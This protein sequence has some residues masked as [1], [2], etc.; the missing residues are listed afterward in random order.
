ML[1]T[2]ED[3]SPDPK[4][5]LV[6]PD[7][8]YLQQRICPYPSPPSSFATLPRPA[9]RSAPLEPEMSGLVIRR[10]PTA[11]YKPERAQTK[12]VGLKKKWDILYLGHM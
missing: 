12:K 8:K 7:T 3:S 4:T 1:R 5:E 9:S 2:K 10:H 11:S 6:N